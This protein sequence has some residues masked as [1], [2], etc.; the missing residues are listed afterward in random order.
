MAVVASPS[1]S[2][3]TLLG[4]ILSTFVLTVMTTRQAVGTVRRTR[5]VSDWNTARYHLQV[6]TAW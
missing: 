4:V 6:S 3:V 1:D 2:V 5:E